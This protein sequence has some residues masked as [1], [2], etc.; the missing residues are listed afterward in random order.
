MTCIS[1][2]TTLFWVVI[3]HPC[4]T[5]MVFN[6]TA[7]E[8]R[9]WMRNYIPLFY[10]EVISVSKA[11]C[12]VDQVIVS[13]VLT[14]SR[15]DDVIKWKH[16]PRYWPFVRGLHRYPVNSP[17]KGQWREAL[18]FSWLCAWING[19]VNNDEA[20]D[21]RRH[22]AHYGVIVM[23]KPNRTYVN[24][25]VRCSWYLL[26]KCYVM[27]LFQKR[28]DGY[29]RY[30]ITDNELHKLWLYK[31]P[32]DLSV[33][34]HG[35]DILSK[36][37]FVIYCWPTVLLQCCAPPWNMI[38]LF[39]PVINLRYVCFGKLIFKRKFVGQDPIPRR[40]I[41]TLIMFE[42]W[43]SHSQNSVRCSF[44]KMLIAI[45]IVFIVML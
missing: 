8:V 40:Y 17:H 22:R 20:G 2:S 6:S 12:W 19:W 21:L 30:K 14:F 18:M 9:A 4:L 35:Y 3:C 10:M 41:E 11:G 33:A 34:R 27:N 13:P 44:V 1:N 32:R 24:T 23:L 15:H 5:S 45:Q 29:P 31:L 37:Y 36:K 42:M 26:R 39:F 25:Y 7:V 16:F 28:N 43:V 38:L